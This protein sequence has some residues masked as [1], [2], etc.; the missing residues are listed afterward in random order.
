MATTG[1]RPRVCKCF[2]RLET[3][4][5]RAVC[6]DL[7][8]HEALSSPRHAAPAN[9]PMLAVPSSS[10]SRDTITSPASRHIL[11]VQTHSFRTHNTMSRPD[12]HLDHPFL[13]PKQQRS[14]R[15]CRR[16]R[17]RR[18]RCRRWRRRD[19]SRPG[20]S[21]ARVWGSSLQHYSWSHFSPMLVTTA[22]QRYSRLFKTS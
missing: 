15:C 14:P 16:C 8:T 10:S 21:T 12:C 5:G 22:L 3:P 1:H 2:P 17:C 19:S 9:P 6:R 20:D 13:S 18:C 7:K 11:I 4:H